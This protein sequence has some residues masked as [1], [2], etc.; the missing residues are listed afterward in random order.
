MRRG[1]RRPVCRPRRS[2][3][4]SAMTLLLAFATGG[5]SVEVTQ[6][7]GSHEEAAA[8]VREI[9]VTGGRDA[10]HWYA[11]ARSLGAKRD[12]LAVEA[13][14]PRI[15]RE[16]ADSLGTTAPRGQAPFHRR[17]IRQGRY[18]ASILASVVRTGW[19]AWKPRLPVTTIVST[20]AVVLILLAV[21]LRARARRGLSRPVRPGP[22]CDDA[23]RLRARIEGRS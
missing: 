4:T 22:R 19:R 13:P 12:G 10:G 1:A 14:A 11:L 8:L 3:A 5:C 7:P 15:A 17:L 9:L 6:A 21:A 2:Y 20:L 23:I 18:S 16:V